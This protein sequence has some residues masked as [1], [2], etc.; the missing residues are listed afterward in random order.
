MV[1]KILV[2]AGIGILVAGVILYLLWPKSQEQILKEQLQDLAGVLSRKPNQSAA[3][4]AIKTNRLPGFFAKPTTLYLEEIFGNLGGVYSPSE[5][6]SMAMRFHASFSEISI[7][8]DNIYVELTPAGDRAKLEFSGEVHAI[9][10]RQKPRHLV[11]DL[12]IT[13]IYDP[14]LDT[15]QFAEFRLRPVLRK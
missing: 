9:G 2:F 8:V 1:K 12:T 5:L 14:E 4:L 15:W 13:A 11:R 7:K 6:T 3:A 10:S